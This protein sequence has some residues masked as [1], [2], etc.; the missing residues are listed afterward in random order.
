ME[1]ILKD[2]IDN[3]T[4]GIIIV[5]TEGIIGIHN[6]KAREIFGILKSE[7][8]AHE[9]GVIKDGD[10]NSKDLR[11]IGIYDET[12]EQGDSIL[13]FGIYGKESAK[14]NNNCKYKVIKP[15]SQRGRLRFR[16]SFRWRVVCSN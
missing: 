10:L 11:K 4:E 2:V 7:I 9:N 6:K 16:C 14:E 5:D 3:I 12:I 1:A 15:I 13:C 8:M